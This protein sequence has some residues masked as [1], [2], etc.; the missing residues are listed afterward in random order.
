M[1]DT[2][3]PN[4]G[5]KAAARRAL[6]W[7]EDGKATGAGTP[8]GWGRA[9]DIVNGSTVATSYIVPRPDLGPAVSL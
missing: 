2:Y 7:K 4:A 8:V 3:T 6:K 1:A 9:T 5:M